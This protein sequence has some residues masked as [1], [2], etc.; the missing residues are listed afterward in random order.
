MSTALTTNLQ[1]TD[2]V[3]VVHQQPHFI[4]DNLR[5]NTYCERRDTQEANRRLTPMVSPDQNYPIDNIS[6]NGQSILQDHQVS[7]LS[8]MFSIFS[9]AF[10]TKEEY[11]L[12]A[13]K[14]QGKRSP[15]I[16]EVSAFRN[17]SNWLLEFSIARRR[18]DNR[19]RILR[20]RWT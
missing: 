15:G 8:E 11:R 19:L 13:S 9:E 16:T 7:A 20:K 5:I 3:H 14:S 1:T 6:S 4:Q 10:I 2:M 12:D 18:S 17:R